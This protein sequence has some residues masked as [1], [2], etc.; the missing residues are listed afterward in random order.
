VRLG[1]NELTFCANLLDHEESNIKPRDE[2]QLGAT[3]SVSATTD[4]RASR[5]LWRWL[6]SLAFCA[7]LF[8]WWYYHRRTV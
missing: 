6:V 8:E 4:Q 5:E 7:L 1:T 3:T 2:L